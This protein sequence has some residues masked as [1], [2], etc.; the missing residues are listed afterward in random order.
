MSES[1]VP[2]L[3][4]P[5]EEEIEY[6]VVYQVVSCEPFTSD[7]Q[8]FKGYRLVLQAEGDELFAIPLWSR[9]VVGRR[10]KMGAFMMALG[11]DIESWPG[12]WVEFVAWEPRNREVIERTPPEE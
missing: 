4:L 8:G 9:D 10:S 3:A 12:R 2:Q 5:G 1:T 7:V 6:G 11:Q